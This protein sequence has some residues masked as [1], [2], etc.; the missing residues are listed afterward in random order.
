VFSADANDAYKSAADFGRSRT[1]SR[2]AD[3][4]VDLC[5]LPVGPGQIINNAGGL[6]VGDEHAAVDVAC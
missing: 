2:D 5:I 3:K 1:E 4:P 6:P